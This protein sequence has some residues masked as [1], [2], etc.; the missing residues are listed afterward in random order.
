MYYFEQEDFS[1]VHI[2]P[3]NACNFSCWMC[4]REV[5]T[6]KIGFMK[7]DQFKDIVLDLAAGNFLDELHFGGFGEPTLHPELI[8]MVA[9]TKKKTNFL[10]SLTSNASQFKKK[11]YITNLLNSGLDVLVLSF[12][13]SVESK[14]NESCPTS[15]NYDDFESSILELVDTKLKTNSPM[16]IDIAFLK[17]TLYSRYVLDIKKNEFLNE[18][19]IDKFLKKL[20]KVIGEGIPSFRK[21]TSG[22]LSGVKKL[23]HIKITKDIFLRFDGLGPWTSSVEKYKNKEKSFPSNFGSCLGLKTH[24]SI[25]C[26]GTV[27]TCCGDFDAKNVLGNIFEEKSIKQILS[28]KKAIRFADALSKKNMP[29]L[30]CKLCRGGKNR[31]EKWVNALSSMALKD[32]TNPK[33]IRKK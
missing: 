28:S 6:R 29:T 19:L 22:F 24:F 31:K 26:D 33:V 11:D 23:D 15:F 17:D 25:Y 18:E 32:L 8:E 10:I 3:T 1:A 16:R 27:S 20:E 30:T 5:M 13:H 4:P 9:F 2:E 14:L 7:L 21:L 12:R